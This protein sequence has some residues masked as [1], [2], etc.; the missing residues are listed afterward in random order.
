MR[1]GTFEEELW[2]RMV[3]VIL[4]KWG[5]GLLTS[6]SSF[7]MVE[8]LGWS[9]EEEGMLLLGGIGELRSGQILSR[10]LS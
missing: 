8:V 1:A 4:R 7:A 3:S 2:A 5:G 6:Y 10:S 9:W